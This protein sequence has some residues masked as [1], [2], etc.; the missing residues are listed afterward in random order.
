MVMRIVVREAHPARGKEWPVG[1][2]L[3]EIHPADGVDPAVIDKAIANGFVYMV[4]AEAEKAKAAEVAK[5]AAAKAKGNDAPPPASGK[6]K[7]KGGKPKTKRPKSH[8]K[9]AAAG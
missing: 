9:S 2:V 5:A 4:D 6:S 8:K 7:P 1:A 3:G